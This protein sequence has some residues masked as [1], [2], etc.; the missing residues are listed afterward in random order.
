VAYRWIDPHDCHAFST[1]YANAASAP[2][3]TSGHDRLPGPPAGTTAA[4]A[5]GKLSRVEPAAA[6]RS[7]TPI[8][9]NANGLPPLAPGAAATARLP[10]TTA[11]ENTPCARLTTGRPPDS[12][13]TAAAL[14][15]A[16]TAP[17]HTPTPSNATERTTTPCTNAGTTPAAP[18]AATDTG[19]THRSARSVMAP[20][21]R[22]DTNA[23][24][25]THK[26]AVPSSASLTR[27]C[28]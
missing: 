5:V 4:R 16:S 7:T 18:S 20:I 26:S 24:T 1:R 9:I 25:P 8:A 22:I 27:A 21:H 14:I 3:T 28:A 11:R 17:E 10:T 19:S 12:A 23:P 13:R 6:P 2:M 15:A